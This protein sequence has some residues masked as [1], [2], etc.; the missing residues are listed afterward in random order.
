[1]TT[2]IFTSE[3]LK[4]EIEFARENDWRDEEFVN[5]LLSD[6]VDEINCGGDLNNFRNFL[7]KVKKYA[8]AEKDEIILS[9]IGR[10]NA[11][12]CRKTLETY[13]VSGVFVI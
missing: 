13:I 7:Q 1:M 2:K 5:G 11:S 8:G 10:I 9:A 6:L 12:C 4:K 3:E